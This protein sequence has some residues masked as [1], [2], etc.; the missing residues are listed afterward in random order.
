MKLV[1]DY[2]THTTYTHGKSTVEQNVVSAI[3]K[4]L[5]QIAI[6]EH[7][8]MHNTNGITRAGYKRMKAEIEALRKKY[9]Q[10]EI[11]CGLECNLTGYDGVID[12]SNNEINDYDIIVLGY[13]YTYKPYSIKNFFNFFLPSILK[14]NS[15][16]RIE[17][18]TQAY[19]TA[20]E[21]NDID[22]LA[23]LNYGIKVDPVKI[24]RVAKEKE[25][26]IELNGKRIYFS[27]DEMR[28]M[29]ETGVKFIIDSDAH[30][31]KNVGKNNQAFA[32][33]ER[34]NI[35]Q[36]QIVNLSDYPKLKR[37]NVNKNY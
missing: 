37:Y 12:I 2:H 32:L 27:D 8:Y 35:P 18:N 23:H 28:A 13:H 30:H 3:N 4:G 11:L 21:K 24:A 5:G 16:K 36:N 14:I 34:L 9:P 17:R 1:G 19:I 10:I 6:T 26:Y 7:A 31:E 33:I 25:I 22:I 15:K 29:V 20:M